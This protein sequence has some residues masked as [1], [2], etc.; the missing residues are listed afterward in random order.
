MARIDH[1]NCTHPR[2]PAGRRACRQG[3]SPAPAP[4]YIGDHI[5]KTAANGAMKARMD[6]QYDEAERTIDNSTIGAEMAKRAQGKR[7]LKAQDRRMGMASAML[8]DE[9][10]M[11]GAVARRMARQAVAADNARIQPRR[12]GARV[13]GAFASC[14]QAALHI[15]AHGGRC[16]CGWAA[17]VS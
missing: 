13:S 16:A 3:G 10:K 17:Q 8:T 15:D 6:R 9:V 14:V 1:T 7:P 2:T 11:T 4:D 12:S 5:R